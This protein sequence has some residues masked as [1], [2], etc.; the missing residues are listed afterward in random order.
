M[1]D[2]FLHRFICLLHLSLDCEIVQKF[3]EKMED[4]DDLELDFTKSCL[5]S[6][7]VQVSCKTKKNYNERHFKK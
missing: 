5:N 2:C 4:L 1:F 3:N 6:F 7:P